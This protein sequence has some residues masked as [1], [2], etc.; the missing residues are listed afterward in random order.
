MSNPSWVKIFSAALTSKPGKP[1]QRLA[2]VGI[3]N[4]L[5]ADDAVGVLVV[6][7]LDQYLSQTNRP[8][9][10]LLIEG[11]PAPENFTAPLRRFCP[12]MVLLIDAVQ[13]E[14]AP[15]TTAWL[16][17]QNAQGFSA[18]THT[19]PPT[20]FGQFL[21]SELSCR[22]ALLGIQVESV[23]FDQP[24]APAV[25]KAATRLARRLLKILSAIYY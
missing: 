20:L 8:E 14:A 4:E 11:G 21:T 3:G 24:I 22:V 19:L 13:M 17:W 5:N 15:G 12:N 10:V 1:R 16:E 25:K 9:A 18:S 7:A 23:E 2:V 6:R